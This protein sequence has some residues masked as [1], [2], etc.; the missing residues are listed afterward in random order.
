M[1]QIIVTGDTIS[2]KNWKNW[3]RNEIFIISVSDAHFETVK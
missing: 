1:I 3:F 2:K